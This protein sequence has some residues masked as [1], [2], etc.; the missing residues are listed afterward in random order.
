[1]Q[2]ACLATG[3][4]V[5][6]ALYFGVTG[7]TNDPLDAFLIVLAVETTI[8]AGGTVFSHRFARPSDVEIAGI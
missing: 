5:F 7:A 6:G 2:Q 1:M 4:A 3:V 8:A